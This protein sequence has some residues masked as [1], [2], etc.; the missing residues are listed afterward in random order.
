MAVNNQRPVLSPWWEA[1]VGKVVSRACGMIL[2][3]IE[4]ARVLHVAD[5]LGVESKQSH[6]L[7]AVTRQ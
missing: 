4:P 7:L 5:D 6:D 2:L 3:K 1:A